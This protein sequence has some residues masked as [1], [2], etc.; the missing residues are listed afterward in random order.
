MACR[1]LFWAML[2]RGHIDLLRAPIRGAYM[3]RLARVEWNGI[4]IDP[5]MRKLIDEHFPAI[6]PDLMDEANRHY[7]KELFVGK[8]LRP[9]QPTR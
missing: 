9:A 7:R 1:R 3:A 5:N 8:T 6:V 2:K 4:P